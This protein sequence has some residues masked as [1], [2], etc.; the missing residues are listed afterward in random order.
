VPSADLA[1]KIIGHTGGSSGRQ[2][3]PIRLEPP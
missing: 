2:T 1:T 3:T